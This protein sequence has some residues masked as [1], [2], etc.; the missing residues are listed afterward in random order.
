MDAE[1][2]KTLAKTH[3]NTARDDLANGR[4][5]RFM[6]GY[7]CGSINA[8]IHHVLSAEDC[9]LIHNL[10]NEVAEMSAKVPQ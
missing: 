3:A 2:A 7:H 6:A 10:S 1:L 9:D 5:T 8:M 4:L